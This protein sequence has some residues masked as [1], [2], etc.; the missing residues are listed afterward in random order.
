[1]L[2]SLELEVEG[3]NHGIEEHKEITQDSFFLW[4]YVAAVDSLY[5][6]SF[7]CYLP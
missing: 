3:L 4:P 1:M 6:V 7:I 5:N 2:A